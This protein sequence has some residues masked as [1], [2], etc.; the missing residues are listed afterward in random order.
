[1]CE[2]P[3]NVFQAEE[4]AEVFDGFSIGSNDLTQ[5]VL[6][7]DRD[8]EVIADLFNERDPAVLNAIRLA[9]KA[10]KRAGRKIGICGQ[11][12]SDFPEFAAFLVHEGIDSLSLTPDAVL[13]TGGTGNG[14]VSGQGGRVSVIGMPGF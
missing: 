1:M 14:P 4:F 11:G 2:L 3:S 13:Q 8:S 9:I 10:A 12:P 6:G 5:R 7:V